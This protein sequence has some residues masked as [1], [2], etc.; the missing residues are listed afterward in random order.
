MF[1]KKTLRNRKFKKRM[2]KSKVLPVKK[3]NLLLAFSLKN[4]KLKN[5]VLFFLFLSRKI[6][7]VTIQA[8]NSLGTLSWKYTGN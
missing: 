1:E 7:P 4:S 5:L 3:K 8:D 6:A 2:V